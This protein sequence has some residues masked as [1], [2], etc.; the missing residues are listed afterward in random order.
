MSLEK[1]VN[2]ALARGYGHE[3]NKDKELDI[4]L[5]DSM[6]EEVMKI[7][8]KPLPET[9]ILA[10]ENFPKNNATVKELLDSL[11]NIKTRR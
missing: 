1:Q 2:E 11:L 4:A 8:N 9:V 5:I 10:F 6:H 7:F 3:K